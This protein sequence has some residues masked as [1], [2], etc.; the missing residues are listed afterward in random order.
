MRKLF[1]V[2]TAAMLATS[3][4]AVGI[5]NGSFELGTDPGSYTTLAG[6]D[7]SI[8]GWVVEPAGVDYIGTYWTA[9]DGVRSLDM[10]ALDK[11]Q[12][13]QVITGL[14]TGVR[15][16]VGF[17]MSANPGGGNDT[18]RMIVAATGGVATLYTYTR[19]PLQTTSNMLWT[20]MTYTFVASGST[21][22][23]TFMSLEQNP[24]GPALDNVSLSVIPEPGVWAMLGLGFGLAG[25]AARRRRPPIVAA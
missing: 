19:D 21:Q 14:T 5:I 18:K 6:G 15:Y 9:S 7:T 22:D 13:M 2:A 11:G 4:N 25:Y 1:A 16:S 8:T 17:D 20:H 10:S 23:L 3:A 24:S 12:I